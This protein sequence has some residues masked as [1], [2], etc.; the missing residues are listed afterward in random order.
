MKLNESSHTTA[1]SKSRARSRLRLQTTRKKE[2]REERREESEERRER[3]E[4]TREKTEDRPQEAAR[5]PQMRPPEVLPEGP[6]LFYAMPP[7]GGTSGGLSWGPFGDL[8]TAQKH[9]VD[10][11]EVFFCFSCGAGVCVSQ[12]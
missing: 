3:R 7:P 5:G 8:A 4:E 6:T 2:K 10:V 11:S 9:P 1:P 12:G